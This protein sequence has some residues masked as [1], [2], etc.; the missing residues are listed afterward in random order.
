MGDLKS[1][2]I[3]SKTLKIPVKSIAVGYTIGNFEPIKLCV[4]PR[5]IST[6]DTGYI[7]LS[8]GVE[9]DNMALSPAM[10]IKK[11]AAEN[12]ITHFL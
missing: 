12:I 4:R 1:P 2:N 6:I 10:D 3:D 11:L 9:T 7:A 5:N 8:T